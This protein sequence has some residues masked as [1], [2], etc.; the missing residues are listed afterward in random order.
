M[1]DLRYKQIGGRKR[2]LSRFSMIQNR[3]K[4]TH[5][6]KNKNYI[7]VLLLV[8]KEDFVTWFMARDYE[9]CSVD[10]IDKTG[11]YELSNM[12]ILPLKVNIAKDKLKWVC[13]F[14]ECYVCKLTKLIDEFSVD[15][16]RLTTGRSTICK[17]CDAKRYKNVSNA[18]K[19]KASARQ[20]HYY[21]NVISVKKR[22]SK[23]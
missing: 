16:R 15:K 21:R 19:L 12:Q 14:C 23:T 17:S 7:G 22:E 9:G 6:P 18:A 1:K 8:S 5:L 20:K 11:H 4:N 10:R 2:A 3:L 13:S